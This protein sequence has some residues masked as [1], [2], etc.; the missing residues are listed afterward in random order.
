[1]TC[2]PNFVGRLALV[3]PAAELLPSYLGFI[4]EMRALGETIWP[5]RLP[6][7]DELPD[8]FVARLLLKETAP[9]PPA[10]PESVHWGVVDGGLVG[11][12]ALRHR[13][14]ERLAQFGGN[15][16][17]EVRPSGRR[18]GVATAM[19]RL[20]LAT[21]PARAIGRILMT[22]SP[23]NAG[24]RKAIEAN[25]GVLAGIVFADE[26]NRETCHYWIDVRR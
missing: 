21:E 8:A 20:L 13:L 15:I 2:G 5:S 11:F 12:I 14:N 10:V 17:Y 3:R 24:S 4:E 6:L 19:L 1:M 18:Q 22:C 26:E 7:S 16:G 23:A 25:G 9:E